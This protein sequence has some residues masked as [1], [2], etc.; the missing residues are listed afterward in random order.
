MCKTESKS[1]FEVR[2]YAN[3]AGMTH[4]EEATEKKE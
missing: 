1:H 3:T 2:I 4:E